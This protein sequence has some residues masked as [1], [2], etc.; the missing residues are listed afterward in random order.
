M[1]S[2]KKNCIKERI[3]QLVRLRSTGTPS[4]LAMKFEISERSI[5]RIIRE[6]R[7]AG[8]NIRYDYNCVS[9]VWAENE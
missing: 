9:Y 1:N 4:E 6:L 2:Y 8:K 3:M 5:K 7:E